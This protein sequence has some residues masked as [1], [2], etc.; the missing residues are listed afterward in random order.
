MIHL[1]ARCQRS[2]GWW[3]VDVPELDGLFT[4]TRRLDQVEQMVREA[5]SLLTDKP[6]EEFTV[7][8]VPELDDDTIAK[9]H[10]VH[11]AKEKLRLAEKEAAHA[12]RTAAK[13]LAD[14]GL[15]VRDIG[16]ILDISYQRASQLLH[17]A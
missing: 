13:T 16:T 9:V 10:P 3:A 6:E 1:T 14:Q 7:T 2:D 5:A 11:Q 17:A 4:Q 15:T 12:N 8:V